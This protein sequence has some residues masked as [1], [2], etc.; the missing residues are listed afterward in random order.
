[1]NILEIIGIIEIKKT[2]YCILINKMRNTIH[3]QNL[4]EIRFVFE[5]KA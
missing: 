2:V 4:C 5:Y 1:M 3:K